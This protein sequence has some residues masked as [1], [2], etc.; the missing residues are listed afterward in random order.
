MSASIP[1]DMIP[2]DTD[3]RV[4][5]EPTMAPPAWLRG[6]AGEPSQE[7][8]REGKREGA[9]EAAFAAVERALAAS[10]RLRGT[11]PPA[12]KLGERRTRL[13]DP[14]RFEGDLAAMRL[15]ERPTLDPVALTTPVEREGGSSVG[16]VARIVGAVGLAALAAFFIVGTTPFS[17]A[18]KTEGDAPSWWTRLVARNATQ[19]PQAPKPVAA[20]PAVL[21]DRFAEVP[22]PA[23]RLQPR[24][25]QTVAV[26]SAA[27]QPAVPQ[28]VAAPP[29]AVVPA[30]PQ[31]AAPEPRRRAL[32]PDEVAILFQ[33]SEELIAQG[34]I[35]GGRLLLTRAAEAGDARS[36]LVLGG[37]YDAAVLGR[38]GVL[39]VAPNSA[40]ARAWYEKAAQFG[41]VEATRRLEHLAQSTR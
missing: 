20:A 27:V 15:R 6:E 36:A 2:N 17:L 16:V 29:P 23:A 40:K 25:V 24:V 18:V 31:A 26:Q 21:A 9:H 30:W 38:L 1:H 41:S 3:D 32:E 11:L 13:R 14:M 12:A 33:R 19:M 5:E 39:G 7:G 22:A 4:L 34:D 8:A 28:P 37:T 10:D 35:A